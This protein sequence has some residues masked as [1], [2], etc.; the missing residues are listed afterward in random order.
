MGVGAGV[1]SGTVTFLFSDVEGSTRLWDAHGED[2]RRA[3]AVHDKV[4]RGAFESAG[5]FVFATGGDGFGAAFSRASDAISASLA[6][7]R[8][9]AG[10]DW[11][12]NVSLR[13]RMGVHTGEAEERGGDYFGAEVSRAARLMAI[14]HGGQIVCSQATADMVGGHLPAGVSLADL[15]VHRLRDLSEPLR[16][17]L[18]AGDGLPGR[19][20]PLLSMDAFP[21]NLPLQVSSF[22]GRDAELARVAKALGE[23]RVVTLTGVGGVGKTRLALRAAAEALPRFREGAWLVELAPVRDPEAVAAA[24]AAVFGVTERVGMNTTETLVEFLRSKQL[25]LVLDNCEHLL[26]PTA[27]LVEVLERSCPGVVVLVTSREGLAIEGERVVPVPALSAPAVNGDLAVVGE[28]DAVRLFVERAGWVDPDFELTE[29]NAPAVAQLCRRL[30]GLPLAIELAAARIRAITPAELAGRLDR[31]FDTLA[32]GRRRA[33]QRHQTLRAAI[34]WSYQL[35]S[36][37]EQRLLAR[38]AVFAGGCTEEAAEEVCGADPLPGGAV[39]ELLAGLV[40]KSLVI[41]QRQGPTTR[42][43]L[44][45]TIREFGEDRLA[46]YGETDQ[47][48]RRHA[49]YYCRLAAGLSDRL[50]GERLDATRRIIAELDN[51]LAALNYAVDTADADLALRILR[52]IPIPAYQLGFAVYLPV[53]TVIGLPGATSHD[54]YPGVLA[55]SAALSASRGELE[56]AEEACQEALNAVGRLGPERERR[57][58]EQRVTG[59]RTMRALALGRWSEAARF[60]ERSARLA[61]QE[62]QEATAARALA[63]AAMSYILAGDP[64]SGM[65]LA[66]EGLQ[67]ARLARTPITVAFCL[68]ASAGTLADRE[69]EHARRLLQ[70]SLDLREALDFEA[71]NEVTQ[72]TLI[73]ARLGD[74]ALTLRLAE[75]SIRHLQWGGQLAWLAGVLNVV[76]RAL[77]ETDIEAAARLQGAARHLAVQVA[78]RPVASADTGLASPG[79]PAAGFSMIGDLRRQTSALLHHDLDEG[80]LRHLRTEGEAMDSDQAVVYALDAIR[81]GRESQHTDRI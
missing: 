48:R 11:P 23:A 77:A 37:P 51:M 80:R 55:V 53:H 54:L 45:E 41:A 63:T 39:F 81:R 73:A 28:S 60:S 19:F 9:L 29:T 76:A 34:D 12:G 47:L 18:V 8:G 2:M 56:R 15:G 1:P 14:A 21:G 13:V 10:Q 32:G 4:V 36:E 75:R 5:G 42:Y 52:H 40:A 46:D 62:G 27:E 44:L 24:V 22:I 78:A 35:L 26:D 68:V 17:F 25:L 69:P 59:T 7:Q 6:A 3:L 30:D 70:D 72:A 43:R 79:E 74:W 50:E 57:W 58:V 38:L 20:P 49:E 65:G 67:L 31:R 61:L 64:D 16:V 66:E 71:P 33:V